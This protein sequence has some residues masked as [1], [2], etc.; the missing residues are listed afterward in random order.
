M[1]AGRRKW[2]LIGLG[3]PVALIVGFVFL[4]RWDWFIPLVESRAS[5]ALGRPVTIS[6]LHVSLA[7]CR[8][9]FLG[10]I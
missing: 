3:I 9:W 6:H 4:W 7:A 10:Y 5:A 2:W 8:S 1:A